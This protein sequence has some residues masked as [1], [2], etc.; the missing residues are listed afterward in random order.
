LRI[1][2]AVGSPAVEVTLPLGRTLEEVP[3]P[4]RRVISAR[5]G[6]FPLGRGVPLRGR[7]VPFEE[8][9]FPSGGESHSVEVTFPSRRVISPREGSPT[10]WT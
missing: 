6:Y 1:P 7:A 9:Y 2:T 3:F 10:P 4:S 8:G 5:E